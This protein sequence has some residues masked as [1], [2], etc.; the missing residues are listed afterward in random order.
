MPGE[1]I[2]DWFLGA[3][4]PWVSSSALYDGDGLVL[5]EATR[6]AQPDGTPGATLRVELLVGGVSLD[7]HE[8]ALT[9]PLPRRAGR[10]LKQ[11][12]SRLDL[13]AGPA[14]LVDTLLQHGFFGGPVQVLTYVVAPPGTDERLAL[15]STVA[16]PGGAELVEAVHAVAVESRVIA[17]SLEVTLGR[18]EEDP[19][20]VPGGAAGL[21]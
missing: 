6:P 5:L 15:E 18:P 2:V 21:G 14:L 3:P 16:D 12:T 17:D 1:R 10:R 8:A 9:A 13:P 19:G 11:E 4:E 20:E 7:E